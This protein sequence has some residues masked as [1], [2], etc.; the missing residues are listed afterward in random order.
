M[1]RDLE[2][3]RREKWGRARSVEQRTTHRQAGS[4]LARGRRSANGLESLPD[5]R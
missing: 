3:Q 1:K 2:T 5:A 4:G